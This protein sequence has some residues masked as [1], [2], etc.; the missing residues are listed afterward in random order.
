MSAIEQPGM[1]SWAR[2]RQVIIATNEL[3]SDTQALRSSLALGQGFHDPELGDYAMVDHTFALADGSGLSA[4]NLFAPAAFVRLLDFMRRHPKAG[5]FLAAL[6]RSTGPGTLRRRFVAT[7]LEGQV[8]AKTG[9]IARVNTLSGYIERADGKRFTFSIQ[10][11]AHTVPGRQILAQI[12]S[13]VVEI[14]KTS[15]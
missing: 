13:I 1:R 2:L 4:T 7:P 15:R 12:D 10:A 11:N 9:N 3:E 14:G 8:V 5:P 6:P